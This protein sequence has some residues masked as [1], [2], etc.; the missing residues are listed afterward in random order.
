M[1]EHA[2]AAAKTVLLMLIALSC[3][4]SAASAADKPDAVFAKW[5]QKFQL[6]V[7]RRDVRAIDKG[8]E[9][10][11]DWEVSADVRAI[12]GE[13]DFAANFGIFFTNDVIKNVLAGKP[14]KL[15]NGNYVLIWKSG[16]KEYSIIFRYYNGTYALDSLGEGPP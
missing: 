4:A 15:P 6:A 10:P 14:E 7:M 13:S 1:K 16:G 8:V 9:F 2:R 3:A 5:W 11:M 12:R